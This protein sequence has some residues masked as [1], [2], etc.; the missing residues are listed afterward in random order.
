MP[1]LLSRIEYGRSEFPAIRS[2]LFPLLSDPQDEASTTL[3][4]PPFYHAEKEGAILPFPVGR[5]RTPLF[6]LFFP[7]KTGIGEEKELAF[8][9]FW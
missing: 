6:F 4:P 8:P 3:F 5:K 2:S 1:L 7:G 9:F